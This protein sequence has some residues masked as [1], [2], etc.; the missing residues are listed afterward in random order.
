M[1]EFIEVGTEST[2]DLRFRVLGTTC[3]RCTVDDGVVV[4]RQG[5]QLNRS[6]RAGGGFR[7][8]CMKLEAS[9]APC[10]FMHRLEHHNRNP[11]PTQFII[12]F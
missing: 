7:I 11:V 9:V 3:R 4:D 12:K 2:V 5:T 6:I 1:D 10:F 8:T